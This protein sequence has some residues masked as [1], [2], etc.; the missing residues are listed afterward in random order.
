VRYPAYLARPGHDAKIEF[1]RVIFVI[2]ITAIC[3]VLENLPIRNMDDICEQPGIG[4]EFLRPVTGYP[5]TGRRDIGDVPLRI[6]PVFPIV[7][8]IGHGPELLPL[9]RQGRF[10]PGAGRRQRR[11]DRRYEDKEEH[12]D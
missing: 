11:D 12:P 2:I 6:Y 3:V 5:L 10:R 8:V 7:S 1:V 9:L 4:Q